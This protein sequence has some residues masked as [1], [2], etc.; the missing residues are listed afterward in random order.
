[1]RKGIKTFIATSLIIIGLSFTGVMATDEETS[2]EVD[3]SQIMIQSAISGDTAAG[4]QAEQERNNKIDR[5]GLDYCYVSFNDLFLVS[6]IMTAEAGS[7]WLP[8]D[9]KMAVGEV[10]LNRVASPEFPDTVEDCIYQPGQY[11]SRNSYFFKQL[12]PWKKEVRLA[13]RLLNGERYLEPSVVFQANFTQGSG[14][15]KHCYDRYL[16]ST[17]FCYSSRTSLYN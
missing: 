1:M 10:L 7:Y 2:P 13:W 3:Y 4:L 5:L 15:A 6:K 12:L 11:Y 14:I 17:Y 16:G 8:D 9:W